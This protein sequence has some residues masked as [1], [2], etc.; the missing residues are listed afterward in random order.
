MNQRLAKRLAAL[1]AATLMCVV[2]L[3]V[4]APTASAHTATKPGRVQECSL[5]MQMT[6]VVARDSGDSWVEGTV[7]YK[8]EYVSVCRWVTKQVPRPHIHVSHEVCTIVLSAGAG[9]A[10]AATGVGIAASGVVAGATVPVT[11]RVC[12]YVPRVIYYG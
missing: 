3:G 5:E 12:R 6:R 8:P 4:F 2:S 10:T 11:N 7:T 1:A 9:A